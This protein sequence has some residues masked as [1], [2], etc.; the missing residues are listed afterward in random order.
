MSHGDR[1]LAAAVADGWYGI[2]TPTGI[3]TGRYGR[4][5]TCPPDRD[6]YRSFTAVTSAGRTNVR[7]H[8]LIAAKAWGI[9]AIAG[10]QVAHR[11]GVNTDNRL[12]NLWLPASVKEHN[13]YDGTIANLTYRTP[14]KT[15]W[16]ACADCGT[17]DGPLK[18]CRTPARYSG[19]RFGIDG[20]LCNTCYQRHCRRSDP[21][22]YAR[23]QRVWA[24]RNREAI[25]ARKRAAYARRSAVT[26]ADNESGTPEEVPL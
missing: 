14:L 10:R 13:E 2:D 21:A 25:N 22:R 11:N 7:V 15:S 17:A 19:E 8:R 23:Y 12:A 5:L 24:S 18:G 1:V 20:E 16:S 3:V 26:V 4:R 6:G 9:D